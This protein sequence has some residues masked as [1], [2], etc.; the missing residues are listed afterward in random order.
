MNKDFFKMTEQERIY[1]IS[2]DVQHLVA[3]LR[4][5]E[6]NVRNGNAKNINMFKDIAYIYEDERVIL[7]P[8]F[9]HYVKMLASSAKRLYKVLNKADAWKGW[10]ENMK[11]KL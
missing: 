4:V 8:Q 1:D 2:H 7:Q 3:A 11:A 6:V 10:E 5:L 9:K